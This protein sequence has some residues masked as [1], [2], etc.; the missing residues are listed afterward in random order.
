MEDSKMN[1][2]DSQIDKRAIESLRSIINQSELLT[3][4]ASENLVNKFHILLQRYQEKY[5]GQIPITEFT[6]VVGT[7]NS[8]LVIRS[9]SLI[10]WL[11]I[12]KGKF[13][14]IV[15]DNEFIRW[16]TETLQDVI[17]HSDLPTRPASLDRVELFN[18]TL[19]GCQQAYKGWIPI[20]EFAEPL[21]T[22]N[23]DLV[24]RS[25]AFI[26]FLDATKEQFR[27]DT[28]TQPNNKSIGDIV[29]IIHDQNSQLGSQIEL[30]ITKELKLKTMV[31]QVE[32]RDSQNLTE[33]F[34]NAAVQCRFAIFILS[35]DDYLLNIK[36]N[37]SI[38]RTRQDF[39][40]GVGYFW[41]LLG[42]KENI[43]FLVEDDAEME[44]LKN[45]SGIKPI[46]LTKDLVQTK[47]KLRREFERA[48]L[49]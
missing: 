13:G 47:L 22:I 20:F 8:D 27:S 29:F 11:Q 23:S 44:L 40:L 12:Q 1:S 19:R 37:K 18:S 9:R 26:R 48:G 17:K 14:D 7:I 6:D 15:F 41:G 3:R 2:R 49:L 33:K 16:A 24:T 21:E 36:T 38:K 46:T 43:A 31:M 34:G 28:T 10:R 30:F 42:N 39:V 35:A 25:K 32:L 4:P 5:K 45:I